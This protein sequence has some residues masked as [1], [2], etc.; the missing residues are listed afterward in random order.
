MV[1]DD[2]ELLDSYSI[3]SSSVHVIVIKSSSSS[4]KVINAHSVSSA[5][6]QMYS[7]VDSTRMTAS[8]GSGTWGVVYAHSS[9]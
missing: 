8:S 3:I 1:D 2:D 6:M 7:V 4:N 9:P 5:T